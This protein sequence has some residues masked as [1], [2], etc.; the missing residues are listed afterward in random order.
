MRQ[1]V[2]SGEKN[3]IVSQA[4]GPAGR[5]RIGSRFP[6]A[7]RG[8]QCT[9]SLHTRLPLRGVQ[10]R[11]RCADGWVAALAASAPCRA[12]RPRRT[13][14][15]PAAIGFDLPGDASNSSRAVEKQAEGL[16]RDASSLLLYQSVLRGKPAQACLSVL[17]HLQQG[18]PNKLLEHFG[19]LYRLL[20]A[21]GYGSWKEYLVDQVRRP[22]MHLL[23]A[24]LPGQECSSVVS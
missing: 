3:A 7:D 17:A 19:E 24:L 8:G 10:R 18:A 22:P 15:R 14:T 9:G 21:D 20:A 4:R 23:G 11:P 13:L 6:P 5:E 1:I 12:A 2:S 16:I